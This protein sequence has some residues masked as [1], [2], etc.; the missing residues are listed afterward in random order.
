MCVCLKLFS[1]RPCSI[2]LSSKA[3][4]PA[5]WSLMWLIWCVCYGPHW[6]FSIFLSLS[7]SLTLSLYIALSLSNPVTEA[8]RGEVGEYM[9]SE[10][11][12]VQTT[13]TW[14]V[15]HTRNYLA[16]SLEWSKICLIAAS[17][18]LTPSITPSVC[19]WLCKGSIAVQGVCVCFWHCGHCRMF[20]QG[21]LCLPYVYLYICSASLD[22]I[23]HRLQWKQ[24]HTHTHTD[25]L[26]AISSSPVFVM[27]TI[28]HLISA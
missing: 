13:K 23:A 28:P 24:H 15:L 12:P 16:P 14:P 2:W 21:V 19:W 7:H 10:M 3:C 11:P 4:G 18:Q 20:I 8:E 17:D 25:T 1:F 6:P 27:F 26:K 5:L 9:T 22:N